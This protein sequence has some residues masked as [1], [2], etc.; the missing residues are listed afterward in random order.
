M[1]TIGLSKPY[2]AVYGNVGNVVSYSKGTVLGGAVD[3]SSSIESS[4]DS[5]LYADNAIKE[6]DRSFA[7][8]KLSI[9]TDDL[10]QAGSMLILGMTGKPITVPGISGSG[11]SELIYDDDANAPYL[12]F[13]VIIQ[14]KKDGVFK[15]RAVVFTK[16]MFNIPEDAA[17]TAG[18]SIEWQT[19]KLEATIMRDDT[20]KR[21]WKR[22]ATLDSEADAEK[23]I[24]Y[25]LGVIL[26]NLTV[27]S[28][29]GLT[30]GKTKITVAPTL[31]AGNSYKYKVGTS[32]TAP[33]MDEV[34]SSGYTAWDGT[35]EIT[36]ATGQDIL[37]VEVDAGNLAKK[38][39]IVA[40]VSKV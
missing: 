22:E 16:I 37:V 12:G 19:P 8:G 9:T 24:K 3:F 7:G 28:A 29:A 26:G 31:T 30:T 13:G 25:C 20:E 23:Y 2:V 18:E 34:I 21:R 4:K 11:L 6:S 35:S 32:L 5:N 17:K 38:A 40:V 10:T 36:A 39:G 1:A 14:K 33:G 27:S 15:Y